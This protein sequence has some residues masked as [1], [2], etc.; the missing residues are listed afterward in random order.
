MN[1]QPLKYNVV[2]KELDLNKK[3]LNLLETILKYYEIENIKDFISPKFSNT[4]DPFKLK[5]MQQAIELLFNS[6]DKKILME[7]DS[8]CDGVTSFSVMYNFIKLINPNTNID[9]YIHDGKKHGI[10]K[11][12]VKRIKKEQIELLIVPDGG[13]NDVEFSK[14][15]SELGCKIL[16]IDHHPIDND[17]PYATIIN[18]RDK[19]YPH[20][21]LSGSLMCIKFIE[22]YEQTYLKNKM[23]SQR[24]YSKQ[25]YDLGGLGAIA[26]MMDV[27]NLE[28]RYYMIEGCKEINN[29]ALK[30]LVEKKSDEFNL[31]V[32]I[33][34]SAFTIAPM[35]N[36]MCRYGKMDEKETML[37]AFCNFKEDIEYQPR[38][39]SKSDPQ[40]PKEIH[41]LQKTA[42]RI[43]F[44]A[45]TRQDNAAEKI[46]ETIKIEIEKL[47]LQKNKV[48]VFIDNQDIIS[49]EDKSLT[50]LLGNKLVSYFGK[51]VIILRQN[52]NKHNK[53]SNSPYLY[54][55][56]CRSR[57]KGKL[58]STIEYFSSL[59][60]CLCQGQPNAF[61]VTFYSLEDINTFVDICNKE[62]TDDEVVDVSE[63]DFVIDA[64]LLKEKNVVD[65]A[66]AYNIWGGCISNPKTLIK[67]LLINNM[68]INGVGKEGSD[69]KG[70]ISFI[71]NG[72]K[73]TKKYCKKDDY[74]NMM[75]RPEEWFGDTPEQIIKMDLLCEF[76]ADKYEDEI[77]YNVK[78]RDFYC[79]AVEFVGRVDKPRA[80]KETVEDVKE[81]EE[82]IKTESKSMETPTKKF[83]R[84]RW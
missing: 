70:Y 52:E 53:E 10:T 84:S 72:I 65:I 25:F 82:V 29:E 77:Y 33:H 21:N 24:F 14:E 8:D 43:C 64:A 50:G 27:R 3:H 41:S 35:I 6:L 73:F 54:Q 81:I 28:T 39:K 16:I 80:E 40:P 62:I 26:D 37:K 55:G 67:N 60:L 58:E 34:N 71:Y 56:S 11:E 15:I 17:N 46:K 49:Y 32:T 44:N 7:Q 57:G 79:E 69:Y 30:E 12:V 5:N 47:K 42:A 78:I 76:Y 31:G 59:N 66:S 4:H 20:E 61:G 13:T 83:D 22:A 23:K 1:N 48:I 18:C 19:Q 74:K 36:A 51:P 45:K 75:C 63:V 9:Y 68:E 2:N 38:R